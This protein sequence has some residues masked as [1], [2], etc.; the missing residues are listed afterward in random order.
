MFV[1][2]CTSVCVCAMCSTLCGTNICFHPHNLGLICQP[3]TKKNHCQNRINVLYVNTTGSHV[4]LVS[5]CVEKLWMKFCSL[6]SRVRVWE[7]LFPTHAKAS[8]THK[9]QPARCSF[10]G[11]FLLRAHSHFI[12]DLRARA[13]PLCHMSWQSSLLGPF[14]NQQSGM[15]HL[16]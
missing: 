3:G 16:G 15:L 14:I 6:Q 7:N 12:E 11:V 4:L 2:Y 10:K 9:C 1:L 5:A 13:R 8:C